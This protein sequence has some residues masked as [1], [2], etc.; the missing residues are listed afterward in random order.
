MAPPSPARLYAT[1]VGALL[2]VLGIVGFF[3]DLSWVNYAH[4]ATGALG[5]LLAGAAPRFYAAVVGLAYVTLAVLGLPD[6]YLWLHL[7]VGA[8]G[9]AAAAATKSVRGS[10]GTNTVPKEPRNRVA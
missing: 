6:G 3:H 9:L 1:A 4:L 10:L 7:A 5:L 8:L 2:F